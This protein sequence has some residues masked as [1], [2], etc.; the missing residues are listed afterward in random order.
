MTTIQTP[1]SCSDRVLV[2]YQGYACM[3]SDWSI[4]T[5]LSADSRAYENP[6]NFRCYTPYNPATQCMMGAFRYFLQGLK[7]RQWGGGDTA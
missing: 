5:G 3:Q 4:A 7:S 2:G 1:L 6:F